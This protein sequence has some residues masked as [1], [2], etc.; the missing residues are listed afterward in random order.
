LLNTDFTGGT[1]AKFKDGTYYEELSRHSIVQMVTIGSTLRI[2]AE[3]HEMI[4]IPDFNKLNVVRIHDVY[5][6]SLPPN[7]YYAIAPAKAEIPKK[8]EKKSY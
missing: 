8:P 6:A 2:Y 7:H 3:D 4:Q 5:F 1:I